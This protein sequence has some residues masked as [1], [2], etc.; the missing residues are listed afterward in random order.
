MIALGKQKKKI[1]QCENKL[2]VVYANRETAQILTCSV[3]RVN[4]TKN[5]VCDRVSV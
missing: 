1:K 4:R 2:G 3:P 5:R